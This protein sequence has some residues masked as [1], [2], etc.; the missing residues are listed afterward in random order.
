[1][2]K[3]LTAYPVRWLL[4]FV[5]ISILL[6]HPDTEQLLQGYGLFTLLGVVGA[7]FANSTGA[8][9][10]VIFV[11]FFNQLVFDSTT[12]VATSF[13]IQCCRMNSGAITWWR[14]YQSHH[15]FDLDWS[16]L[17]LGLKLTV[18][19]SIAGIA[20]GQWF[21][22][23]SGGV[24]EAQTLHLAFGVFSILLALA[25]FSTLGKLNKGSYVQ[26]FSRLD[27]TA[28]VLVS[29]FGGWVTAYLSIGVG[30]LIAVLLIMRGFNV[31]FAIALAVMLSA[32][33]VWSA[34]LF[35]AFYTHSVY[36]PVVLFAGAGA[37]VGGIL[38]KRLVLYFNVTHLKVFFAGWVLIL[39]ISGI[40]F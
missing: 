37:I 31:T 14:F 3:N 23:Q 9:G 33:T 22:Y 4:F 12:T 10:G 16:P 7:I 40:P 15:Q 17:K 1:M 21:Q 26:Q 28:L 39:G 20:L 36:W 18:P 24:G 30:E 25:I 6:F 38:A 2:I 13:A 35:H 5:W 29:V 34:V 32:M 11:P 27:R 8:G 19:A